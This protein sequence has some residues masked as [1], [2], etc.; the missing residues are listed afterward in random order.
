MW[1][2]CLKKGIQRGLPSPS[3][4]PQAAREMA[5]DPLLA[6][7]ETRAAGARADARPTAWLDAAGPSF[8]RDTWK[9]VGWLMRWVGAACKPYTL[10]RDSTAD[11]RARENWN[12]SHTVRVPEGREAG[13]TMCVCG[14]SRSR[15]SAR[16]IGSQAPPAR[17][18]TLT[19]KAWSSAKDAPRLARGSALRTLTSSL[20]PP[21]STVHPAFDCFRPSDAMVMGVSCSMITE[22]SFGILVIWGLRGTLALGGAQVADGSVRTL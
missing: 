7:P 17:D 4:L 14:P 12:R 10:S 8:V 3:G 21:G 6:E 11:V 16:D 9:V 15:G 22:G 20:P 2:G 1:Y 19:F 5:T 18:H 13:S